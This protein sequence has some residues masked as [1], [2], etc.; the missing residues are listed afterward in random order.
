MYLVT[1]NNPSGAGRMT[2][3]KKADLNSANDIAEA[4][5]NINTWA[6]A[7]VEKIAA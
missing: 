4:I 1:V 3:T 6:D 2:Y 5:N 7:R